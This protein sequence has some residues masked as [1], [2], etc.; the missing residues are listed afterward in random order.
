[1]VKLTKLVWE[2][3]SCQMILRLTY[4]FI[5]IEIDVKLSRDKNSGIINYSFLIY[6][7]C[8]SR[9]LP[10]KVHIKIET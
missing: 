2:C 6:R 1:M 8:A 9:V 3:I 4:Y 10:K 7:G 5:Q